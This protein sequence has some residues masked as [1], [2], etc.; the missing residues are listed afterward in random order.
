MFG[1]IAASGACFAQVVSPPEILDGHL[2]E[3]QQKHMADLKNIATQISAHSFPYRL[4]FSRTLDMSEEQQKRSDQRSIRFE[5][6]HDQTVLE[7]TA[8]YYA[9]YSAELMEKEQRARRTLQDVAV[10]M[11]E[12]AIPALA[13]EEAVQAFAIEIS[14]HVRRKILGVSNENYENVALILPVVAAKQLMAARTPGEQEAALLQ[15]QLFVNR[16][17]VEGWGQASPQLAAEKSARPDARTLPVHADIRP[18][19]GTEP[20][21]ATVAML[22][23]E[24]ANNPARVVS[25]PTQPGAETRPEVSADSLRKLQESHQ[26]DLDCLV[27]ELDK[28]AHF[29]S[30]APPV[31]VAFR[32]GSFLQVSLKTTLKETTAGSQYQ[33]AALAF[34][35]H[36]A[37]LIRPVLAALKGT[38]DFDG[39]DFSTIVRPAGTVEGAGVAV[40]FIFPAQGL[41]NYQNYDLTGQQLINMGFVLINGERVSLELQTAEGTASGK[42]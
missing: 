4:Y 37:H 28:Q 34:D 24:V 15:A 10:P 2:R 18:A 19:I 16:Q 40:E 8:N 31:F 41:G 26:A 22:S 14:Q 17:P 5:K 11:L 29:V 20:S 13:G 42:L 21:N 9:S 35:E 25:T 6:F 32:K 12:A 23:K 33:M 3:L 36:I 30:Y 1:M 7:I 38:P 27:R 39:I